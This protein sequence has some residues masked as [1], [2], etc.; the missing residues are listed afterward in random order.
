MAIL[1]Q[2]S[3]GQGPLECQRAVELGLKKLLQ[4]AERSQLEVSILDS[5]PSKH[6]IKSVLLS[7][8]EHP[9]LN[10]F[11]DRW[12]GTM[13]WICSLRKGASRKN[14]YF[15]GQHFVIAKP[16]ELDEVIF[17]SCRSSGAGGQHVNVTNSAVRATHVK[18]GLTVKVQTERSQHANKRLALQWLAHG[19]QELN[20]QQSQQG[21][22]DQR[23][24]HHQM[25]RGNPKRIFE[26]PQFKEVL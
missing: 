3:A 4:E 22:A 14:W 11:V 16:V 1:L 21:K 20:N 25:E 17:E 13:L 26:G 7:I 15:S 23:L 5:S 19:I 18:S 24:A 2:L 12:T 8:G 10:A 9:Q 6:G